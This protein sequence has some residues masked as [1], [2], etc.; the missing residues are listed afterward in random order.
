MDQVE[1]WNRHS[2]ETKV[3]PEGSLKVRGF[4]TDADGSG[5]PGDHPRLAESV[6]RKSETGSRRGI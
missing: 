5:Y 1:E 2:Y 3:G 4:F 6:K